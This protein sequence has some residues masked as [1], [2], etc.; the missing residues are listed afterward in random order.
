MRMKT[1]RLRIMKRRDPRV[2]KPLDTSGDQMKGRSGLQTGPYKG[3][4]YRQE[5]E[6]AAKEGKEASK[7]NIFDTIGAIF[8]SPFFNTLFASSIYV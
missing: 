2:S 5:G 1:E 6:K 3:S 4:P 8:A 7:A